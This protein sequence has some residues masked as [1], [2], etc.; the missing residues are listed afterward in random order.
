MTTLKDIAAVCGVSVASVS[1]ALND[2][3]DISFETAERIRAVAKELGYHPNA[4]AR[5]LKTNRT[6][7]IGVLFEDETHSGLTHEYFSS[8]LDAVKNG[9][10]SRGYDVT[11][12]SHNLGSGEMSFLEH[13]KYRSVDGVVIANVGF[14][15]PAVKELAKSDIPVVSI[16]Y[17][18]K[19]RGAVISDNEQGMRD[20]TEYVY[21]LGHRRIAFIHGEDTAVT[22]YRLKG[23][24]DTC[25]RFGL[26]IPPE[27]IR[28][29]KFHNP[30]N[31]GILTRELLA[32]ESPPTCILYPDDISLLGGMSVLES[33]GL[34]I[35][36]DISI[37]GYDGTRLSQL[38]R[39][40][41]TTLHQD[42]AM[43]GEYAARLL[44][45]A[46]EGPR[47]YVPQVVYVSGQV[48]P[49]NTVGRIA[50]SE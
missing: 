39:P 25:R 11:F 45:E 15:D 18:F 43:L 4:A 24:Q 30:E 19:N 3:P 5:A 10:E 31:S 1:K 37:A 40:K 16:D 44:I 27:Y 13:C 32:L 20:L 50:V 33:L 21:S 23:F 38:L 22:D 47:D 41:L 7:N 26:E 9:V 35:P 12:I 34:Q 36:R 2:A 28:C 17:V 6:H 14:H 49:G 29:G 46:I 42:S 8:V 48:Y